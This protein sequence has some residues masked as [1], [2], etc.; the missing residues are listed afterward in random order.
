M[1]AYE[2]I[3]KPLITEKSVWL[4]GRRYDE[5]VAAGRLAA[6]PTPS[7]STPRPTRPR[8]AMRWSGSTA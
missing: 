6:G 3:I 2:V 8:S 4:S 1:D 7:R 5:T